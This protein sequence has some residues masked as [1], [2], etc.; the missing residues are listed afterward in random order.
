MKKRGIIF[1]SIF[2]AVTAAL[3]GCSANENTTLNRNLSVIVNS[4]A[5]SSSDDS[6]PKSSASGTDK[7]SDEPDS[8]LST[9][10]NANAQNPPPQ[11]STASSSE[12]FHDDIIPAEEETVFAGNIA[13]VG[14]R[15]MILYGANPK[16]FKVYAEALNRYKEALP[17]VNVYS[18]VIPV[19]CEFYAS[20]EVAEKCADQLAHINIVNENLA[21]IQAVDAYSALAEHIG[22]DIYLRTDHHWSQLGG[23]Y[24]AEAFAKA[25]DVP[26]LPLSDYETRKNTGFRGS[27]LRYSENHEIMQNN[28]ED[29]VYYVPKT[30]SY[31]ATYYNYKIEGWDVIGAYDVKK[32]SF[33]VNFGDDRGD[34]Y[35]TF[36]GGDA[37]IVHIETDT[38]ND[39]R[40]L[41]IK[42]SYGNAIVPNL[43]GSFEEIYVTDLRFFS[44]NMIDY[45]KEHNI[46][47]LLFANNTTIAGNPAMSDN[48]DTIRTQKDMGF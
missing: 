1:A 37:K 33:F 27:M 25:A 47:D 17:E 43:F 20:P 21:D 22:E 23:Y 46:T 5:G 31:T 39:R 38:K 32:G 45:I 36:M 15:A 13:I 41:I 48:L 18:M 8:F 14:T 9:V 26:F 19:S 42:D 6:S 34:N 11:S 29:F 30:V 24:A 35:C 7:P 16:N 10:D 44:H 12:E 4:P 3:G 28:P 40:L 2:I